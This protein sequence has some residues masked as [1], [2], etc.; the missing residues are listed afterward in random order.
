ML[1]F[2][3]VLTPNPACKTP[4]FEETMVVA[5][6]FVDRNRIWLV[7]YITKGKH[8]TKF[9]DKK[10]IELWLSE[11]EAAIQ[12]N[13]V[14]LNSLQLE[15]FKIVL[16]ELLY[17]A[18]GELLPSVVERDRRYKIVSRALE[19]E[20]EL[21]YATHGNSVV[22]KVAVE[23]NSTPRNV[24]RY[25]NEYFRGGRHINSLI[26]R[27]GRHERT[28]SVASKK[29]GAKPHGSKGKNV[30]LKDQGNFKKILNKYY[31]NKDRMSLEAVY[32]KLL[33]EE[34]TQQKGKI[35]PDGT[36]TRTLHL[37]PDERVSLGQLRYWAPEVLGL[38]RKEIKAK[39]RQGPDH[40]SNY[41]AR[42][43][44]GAYI[45][46]GPGHIFQMDS[47]EIDVVLVSP[48]DR[49]V[50]LEKVTIYAI[51]DVYTRSFVGLHMASGKASWYEARLAL[52]NAFRDKISV[53]AE[54]GVII[55]DGDWI[56][57]GVPQILLVDNEEFANKISESVGKDLGL[58]VQFSRAYSGD[59]KG[60]VEV[61]F[62][63]FHAMLRN[64]K[65][66]GFQYKNLM[67]RNRHLPQKTSALTP[68]ELLQ[69]LTL[70]VI[71][72]NRCIWKDDYPME[73][74]ASIDGVKNICREYWLWGLRNRPYF[75]RKKPDRLLYLSLLEVG[76]LTVHRTH[77]M[78]K[79]KHLKYRCND[80]RVHL[81]QEK[82]EGRGKKPRL[83]CR[84]IR[85]TVNKILIEVGGE[86]VLGELHSEQQRYM[87]LS[88]PEFQAA[89]L[90]LAETK[91]IHNEQIQSERADV[92]TMVSCIDTRARKIR[93]E[94]ENQLAKIPKMSTKEATYQMREDAFRQ[95]NQKF[96][97]ATSHLNQLP[98]GYEAALNATSSDINE[99]QTTENQTEDTESLDVLDDLLK[100][101]NHG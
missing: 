95:E 71:Y 79:G 33:D 15:S 3:S 44:D 99:N 10:P 100:E 64:E 37:P 91:A 6:I 52:L 39:R 89:R 69:I 97:E 46:M 31:L 50:T 1:N 42:S 56:E 11:V 13:E 60:L 65:I 5:S 45:A 26:S 92:S 28:F 66:A 94:H 87:G 38:S 20:D 70:Y 80:T 34:Y 93:Y 25:L 9:P 21:F 23:F 63:M 55:E 90:R 27:R 24:Q 35:L 43:G 36:L 53:A 82:I 7:P 29:L 59:D 2:D 18:D 75:I 54:C 8:K 81:L 40:K 86:F 72:H 98:E 101:L 4:L 49:R 78:L 58:I 47:T 41:K 88:H 22:A 67:G 85:S 84:Y 32:K 57:S 14:E 76:E 62:N 30:D 51:R 12:S 77:L 83:S 68:K 61:S 19:D 74:A 17:D 96:D 48:Y 73:Q 16:E